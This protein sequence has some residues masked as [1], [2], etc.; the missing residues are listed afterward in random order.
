VTHST[1]NQLSLGD[2]LAAKGARLAA[3]KADGIEPG[4]SDTAERL[5]L[6]I[7]ERDGEVTSETLRAACPPPSEADPRAIGHVFRRLSKAGHLEFVRYDK[8]ARASRHSAPVAV[9]R[10]PHGGKS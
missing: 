5:A 9:W 2:A 1:G 8:A 6:L 7:A 3:E 10:L 4:W